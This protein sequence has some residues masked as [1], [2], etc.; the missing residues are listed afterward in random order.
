MRLIRAGA[1]GPPFLGGGD[2]AGMGAEADGPAGA[3]ARLRAGWLDAVPTQR[4][5][6]G[7]GA[8]GNGDQVRHLPPASGPGQ[9]AQGAEVEADVIIETRIQKLNGLEW[10]AMVNEAGAP[11]QLSL[12]DA[13]AAAEEAGWRLPSLRDVVVAFNGGEARHLS[14]EIYQL[15]QRFWL[16]HDYSGN[17]SSPTG[18]QFNTWAGAVWPHPADETLSVVVV[19]VVP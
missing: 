4:A 18:Y 17:A 12:A 13:R 3:G 2:G 1:C 19:R 15:A 7:L 11:L 14:G 10:G 5:D 16:R 8:G 6:G 9:R